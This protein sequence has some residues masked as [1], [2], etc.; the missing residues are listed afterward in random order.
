MTGTHLDAL[1]DALDHFERTALTQVQAWGKRL[2]DRLVDGGRLLTVGNGGSAA[3]AEHLASEMVGRYLEERPPFSAL[4]LHVDGSALTA[5]TNDYGPQEMFA[6]Q[7]RAHGRPDD[8]LIAFSTSGRSPNVV[9]AAD[10][11]RAAGMVVW[12]FTGPAP[13]PLAAASDDTVAIVAAGTPT[14]Q[15]V[16]QVAVHLLCA[17]FDRR[18]AEMTD[19]VPHDQAVLRDPAVLQG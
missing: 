5:L 18:V 1:R 3:H 15:E 4:A 19:P 14:V 2:A 7:V 10:A 11:A 13:N 12:S 17:A 6:R 8:V 9:A 16:H